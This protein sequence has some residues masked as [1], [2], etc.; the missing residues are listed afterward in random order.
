MFSTRV[1]GDRA[2]NRFSRALARARQ[3]G[4]LI[5]LTVS[6]PTRVGI[7]YPPDLLAGLSDPASLRYS[8]SPFGLH[9][10]REAIARTYAA[11]GLAIAADRIVLT[12]STSEAYSLL[13]KLLCEPG[14]SAVLTP[15]PSYPLFEHLARLD[16]VEQ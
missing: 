8:P 15:V 3:S 14:G 13:F 16:G 6:N 9:E 12:A 1:P 4:S 10:A 11:R 7:P 2:P 5:D